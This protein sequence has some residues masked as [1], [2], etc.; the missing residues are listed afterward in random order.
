MIDTIHSL[1]V[2]SLRELALEPLLTLK[3]EFGEDVT[4]LN[5]WGESQVNQPERLLELKLQASSGKVL[6]GQDPDVNEVGPGLYA[7]YADSKKASLVLGV[8]TEIMM[9]GDPPSIKERV[10]KYLEAGLNVDSCFLLYFTN[11][12]SDTP[13]KNIQAAMETVEKFGDR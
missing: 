8:G 6:E 3:K 7:N 12:V 9:L 5:W 1:D 10:K 13:K 11:F 2:N 4:L